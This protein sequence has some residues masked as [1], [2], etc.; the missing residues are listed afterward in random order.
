MDASIVRLK[1]EL[2]ARLQNIPRD[3]IVFVGVGNRLRGDDATGPEVIDLIKDRV[4][5]AVD[6]DS[7]P[8]NV[9]GAIK[10]LKPAAIVFVD[11]LDFGGRPGG[12]RLIEAREIQEYG[13][14]THNLSLDVAMEYLAGETGAD[15]FLVGVQPERIAEGEEIS[16]SLVEPLSYLADI[17]SQC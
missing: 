11:A 9:T 8:E 10:R 5:H 17:L 6:A 14:S 15:V 4:A 1:E 2:A 7:A 3:S 16:P 13:A 12:V